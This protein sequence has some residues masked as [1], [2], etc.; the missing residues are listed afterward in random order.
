MPFF[1]RISDATRKVLIET[2]GDPTDQ[3]T[4]IAKALEDV[5]RRIIDRTINSLAN[6]VQS[7]LTVA[8]GDAEA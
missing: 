1:V 7:P 8:W 5:S 3:D 6:D 4:M 2:Q